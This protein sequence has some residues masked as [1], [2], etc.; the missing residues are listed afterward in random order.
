MPTTVLGVALG[1]AIV[2]DQHPSA[3]AVLRGLALGAASLV[4]GLAVLPRLSDDPRGAAGTPR[5]VGSVAGW[6]TGIEL[7]GLLLGAADAGAGRLD[8]LSLGDFV[9]Y[10]TQVNSGRIGALTVTTAALITGL[11]TVAYRR[12]RPLPADLVAALAGLAI[13][14]RPATGHLAQQSFG[15]VLDAVHAL[16]AAIWV[17]GLA[18]LA[19]TVRTRGGWAAALPRYSAWAA[20][21]LLVVGGTGV[22]DAGL[23]LR[24]VT[25]LF[26][27]DYG[28]LILAKA[29]GLLVLAGLGWWWRRSWVGPAA[30]HR[31][32]AAGSVRRATLEV[33][34]STVVFGL[35]AVLA[36]A[37]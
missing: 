5:W 6:W 31:M 25:A 18:A 20:R 14:A 16:A 15:A 23:Q 9:D 1:S 17:G 30:T 10:L 13:I 19:L 22:L 21:C 37:A 2:G 12:D 24:T 32:P 35:A 4:L 7:A 29:A 11:A 28:H 26:E 36:T 3:A 8:R 33:A 34:V 27:T